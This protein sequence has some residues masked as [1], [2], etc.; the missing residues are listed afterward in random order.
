MEDDKEGLQDGATAVS[1]EQ[2]NQ[3]GDSKEI[4]DLKNVEVDGA[5]EQNNGEISVQSSTPNPEHSEHLSSEVLQ[6][7]EINP[8]SVD[9]NAICSEDDKCKQELNNEAPEVMS[10]AENG[11]REEELEN[12]FSH[13]ENAQKEDETEGKVK[14]VESLALT[15]T[16][17]LNGASTETEIQRENEMEE[18]KNE[19]D[20]KSSSRSFL[21]DVNDVTGDESGTEEEQ[22]EFMKE[23]ETFH[24][25]RCLDFKPPKFYQEPLN[26]LK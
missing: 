19:P 18:L 1:D 10:S 21:L 22:A 20:V 25:E 3:S 12:G 2:Q 26:C 17:E 4:H 7:E 24:K 11:S 5:T 6:V 8:P 15:T 23:I 16:E 14:E 13:L 9:A